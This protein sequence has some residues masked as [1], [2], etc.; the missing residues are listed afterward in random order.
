MPVAMSTIGGP[1]RT[2]S[3]SGNPFNDMKPLSAWVIGSKPGRSAA[4]TPDG[5]KLLVALWKFVSSGVVIEGAVMKA[6]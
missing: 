2:G 6:A 5:R 4:I 3:P 1:V